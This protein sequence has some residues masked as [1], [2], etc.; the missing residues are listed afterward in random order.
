MS[1]CAIQRRPT[2]E[3]MTAMLR[4]RAAR[5]AARFYTR[6]VAVASPL[7]MADTPAQRALTAS[8]AALV[9]AVA[10]VATFLPPLLAETLGSPLRIVATA[11][12]LAV[13]VLLHWVYLAIAAFRLGRSVAGWTALA[14]A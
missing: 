6:P 1:R 7:P 2:A 5:R 12:A 8:T 11:L 9:V 4:A 14:V 3:T 13:A 10:C